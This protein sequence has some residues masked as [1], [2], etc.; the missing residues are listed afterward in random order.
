[1]PRYLYECGKC[2]VTSSVFHLINE[3]ITECNS[4]H[5]SENMHK[6][7]STPFIVVKDNKNT[8]TVGDLTKEYI[9]ANR[10]ILDVEKSKRES[11]E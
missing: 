5:D 3:T 1:M 6:I 10:E 8:N 7:L 2:H 4:C 9:E 11:Y